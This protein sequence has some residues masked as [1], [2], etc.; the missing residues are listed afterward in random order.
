MKNARL[1]MSSIRFVI[2][3]PPATFTLAI[4]TDRAPSTCGIV[5]GKYPPPI[6]KRPPIPTIPVQVMSSPRH[7]IAKDQQYIP[8]MAFVT[9][10]NGL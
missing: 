6:K 9:D 8:E 1:N 2:T 7:I 10:I 3:N 4:N 5:P